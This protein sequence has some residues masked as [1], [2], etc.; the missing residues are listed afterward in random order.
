MQSLAAIAVPAIAPPCIKT[1]N[2]FLKFILRCGSVRNFICYHIN[3]S[4]SSYSYNWA[5]IT[6]IYTTNTSTHLQLYI[7]VMSENNQS[8]NQSLRERR[9]TNWE[10]NNQIFI[11]L[12][13]KFFSNFLEKENW[14]FPKIL[15]RLLMPMINWHES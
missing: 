4:I 11:Q 2:S 14:K 9:K 7:Y 6:K 10:K 8:I 5:N 3:S 1:C 15:S 13:F 12:F